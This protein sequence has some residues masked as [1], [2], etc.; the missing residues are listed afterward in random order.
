MRDT[1]FFGLLLPGLVPL[2][3]TAGHLQ[4]APTETVLTPPDSTGKDSTRRDI[5]VAEVVVSTGQMLGSK[6][7]ARNR[8]GS[9]YYI[10]PQE[11]Q[12]MGYTDINRLLKSVPGVN[13]YEEDGFGLRPNI[14]LRGTKAERSERISLMEDGMLIA[15]APYAAPAAY[16]FPNMARMQAVEVLKGSSQVQYG[17]F[18]T[19]GAVNLVSTTVPNRFTARLNTSYGSYD[20]FKSYAMVGNSWKHTGFVLEYLH[21]RS[22]GFRKGDP[23]EREGFRRND[24]SGK[25]LVKTAFDSGINHRLE[26]KA[27]Y[28][29]EHSDE[30]YLGLSEDD[31]A[32]NPYFRYAG[33]QRDRLVTRHWQWAATHVMNGGYRWN[34]TTQAY[35]HYFF[36]NWYKLNEVRDGV[37]KAERRTIVD[38]LADPEVNRAYF[39]ILTGA[40]DFSGEA[41][42]LRANHRVYHSRG[43]QSKGEWRG[44]VLGGWLTAEIGLRYHVDDEDRFQQDDGYAMHNGRMQFFLPGLPGSNANRITEA[45][46]WSGYVLTK[47]AKG[48]WTFTAGARYEDVSLLKRDFTAADPRRSGKIRI[49]TPNHARA[50]LPGLGFNVKLTSQLSLLGG[51]HR[52]FAPPSATLYQKAENSTNF[53]GGARWNSRFL[54]V[55]AIGFFNAYRNMLGSDLL[56]G[57]GQGTLEQFNVG[58]ARVGGVELLAQAQPHIGRVNIPLQLTYTFTHTEMLNAFSSDAWGDVHVGDEIPYIFRHAA[59]AQLGAEYR[60]YELNVGLRYNGAMRTVPGQGAM[61]KSETIPSHFIVDA[62]AKARLNRRVTLTLNAINLTN[63]RYLASRHPAGLRV[64]HPFGLYC[65]A[66]LNW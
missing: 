30:T 29:D 58:K 63:A 57:G 61:P 36:R 20:T 23:D 4:H 15:P 46:A 28:A 48:A 60:G 52:G 2:C 27:G 42:M 21:Y 13:V 10:S 9:A 38:V 39:D 12:R 5:K 8:T 16:Y 3:A 54:K 6:F 32:R 50:W 53:E 22:K 45:H 43:I 34:I 64:G 59:N 49:E 62:S 37:T 25:F 47:W 66:I 55:E 11:I 65:G 44:D 56:A 40:R 7:E 35:Y 31:F 26:L 24:I 33:A 17:P 41:L 18:T 14:S 51:V 19:G 1:Y